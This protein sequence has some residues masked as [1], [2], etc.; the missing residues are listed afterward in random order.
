VIYQIVAR[1][2]SITPSENQPL[3][4][5]GW[6]PNGT[7]AIGI[8]SYGM[9][10]YI[11]FPH[12]SHRRKGTKMAVWNDARGNMRSGGVGQRK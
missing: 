6:Y 3:D 10:N 2:G 1:G 4:V 11:Q 7:A 8:V 9:G 5:V 12:Y